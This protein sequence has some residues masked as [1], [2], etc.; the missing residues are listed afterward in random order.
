MLITTRLTNLPILRLHKPLQLPLFTDE[1]CFE[2]FIGEIGEAEV[3]KHKAEASSL[4]KRL[5][6]LPISIAV[7]ASLVREDVRYAIAGMAKDLPADV[8]AMLGETVAALSKRAQTLLAVMAV[9]AP[10]GFRLSLAHKLPNS[11]R[12]RPSMPCRDATDS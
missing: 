4:F 7:A 5:G 11:T 8:T 9:C 2:L 10:E 1:Q 6:Y 12:Q 3:Y